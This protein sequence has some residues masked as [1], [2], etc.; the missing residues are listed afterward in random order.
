MIQMTRYHKID[1]CNQDNG[2]GMRT[3]IWMSGCPHHCHAC[4]SPQT[5][6]EE[7]GMPFDA[8]AR[9]ELFQYLQEPYCDGLTLLGGEPLAHYN[10]E[11]SLQLA[12]GAKT[13]GKTVWCYTGYTYAQV[14]DLEIM[15]YIDVLVDGRFVLSK[16]NPDLKWRGSA[17]QRV[18]DVPMSQYMGEIVLHPDNNIVAKYCPEKAFDPCEGMTKEEII[19]KYVNNVSMTN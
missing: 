12:I 6:H 19:E 10:L 2:T 14:K 15:D 18:I 17:N 4:F 8:N 5:W 16:F 7:S 1:G 9:Q 3:V 13:L 11:T